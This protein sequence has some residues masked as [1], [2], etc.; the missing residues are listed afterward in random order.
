[1][2]KQLERQGGC[3]QRIFSLF[4][5]AFFIFSVF[6][7]FLVTSFLSPLAMADD[8]YNSANPKGW[9]WYN[10]KPRPKKS[11]PEKNKNPLAIASPT[12]GTEE[13]KAFQAIIGEAKAEAVLHPTEENIKNYLILQ[14]YATNNAST[15]ANV[16]K[17]T[18]LDYPALDYG[19]T[20]SP[21][22]NA[23]HIYYDQQ[24][25]KEKE[26][27]QYYAQNYG[28]FFFYRGQN[29]VD[30]SLAPTV[31]SFARENHIALIPI[32]VDQTPISSL[33]DT[34]LNHGQAEKMN[35]RYFPALVLVNPKNGS[36][37]PLGYGFFSQDELSHRFL[38]V[39]TGFQGAGS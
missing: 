35:I 11:E 3:I 9:L 36:F 22:N 32:S 37:V 29:S 25:Q 33:P 4:A 10:V 5:V 8:A 26:A 23:Q 1:M 12:T 20:H 2:K 30:T 27:I 15:F 34:R 7:V 18:L 38:E 24:G 19:V 6:P 14:N 17:K 21:N 28:L 31:V 39:A 16:W 13:L